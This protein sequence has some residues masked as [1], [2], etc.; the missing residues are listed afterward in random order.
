MVTNQ[1][2][3]ASKKFYK[4]LNNQKSLMTETI[5]GKLP[6]IPKGGKPNSSKKK[7]TQKNFATIC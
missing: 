2:K 1:S 7:N 4:K 3:R 6:R 5:A